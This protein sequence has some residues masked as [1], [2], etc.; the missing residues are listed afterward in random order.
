MPKCFTLCA[1]GALALTLP[2]AA[3]ETGI[4][5]GHPHG[6]ATTGAVAAKTGPNGGPVFVADDHPIEMVA[7]DKELT[8]YVLDEDGTPLDTAGASGRAIVTQ[9]GKN[10]T[11]TLAASPPNKLT[12]PLAAPLTVGAKVVLTTKLHG[13][14]IQA[15]FE[16]K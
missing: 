6:T 13:H 12:G 7:T 2:A 5:H 8:F 3:H 1:L 9:G 16:K 4:P 11:V 15:R 10:A 14:S